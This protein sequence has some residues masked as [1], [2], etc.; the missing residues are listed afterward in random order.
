MFPTD[1]QQN[2]MIQG[3]VGQLEAISQYPEVAKP[4][5]AVICHPHPLFAGTMH[6][7]VVHTVAKAFLELGI[8]TVRFN[9]RGVGASQG[10]YDAGRGETDDALAVAAW[11]KQVAP[12]DK[13]WLAG[14]SFG[15]YVAARAAGEL[16][17][18]QL[19]TVAPA[20]EHFD[21]SELKPI[22]CPWLVLQGE[23]DEV[24]P[25]EQVYDWAEHASEQ[26]TLIRFPGVGHFFHGELIALRDAIV[27]HYLLVL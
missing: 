13:L 25:P 27:N 21:F 16:Q 20:V 11:V 22:A 14:F 2:F 15:S 12:E 23:T 10:E 4:I 3:P 7:K 19:L 26:P 6:N 1:K 5:T 9:F 17:P 18:E 8:K 24:V